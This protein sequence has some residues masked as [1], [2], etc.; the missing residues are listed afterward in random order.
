MPELVL[1]SRGNGMEYCAGSIALPHG[2]ATVVFL[3]KGPCPAR[4]ERL[5]GHLSSNCESWGWWTTAKYQFSRQPEFCSKSYAESMRR[6]QATAA[7]IWIG[8]SRVQVHEA[9]KEY[10]A[11]GPGSAFTSEL[12]YLHPNIGLEIRFDEPNGAY[13]P[14]NKVNRP[15]EIRRIELPQ[16]K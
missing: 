9:M 4:G 2:S 16:P 6:A 14:T 3:S 5:F 12:Y 1:D 8:M 10:V 15:V 13:G 11:V 7:K